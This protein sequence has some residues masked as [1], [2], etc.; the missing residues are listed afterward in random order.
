MALKRIFNRGERAVYSAIQ[1]I[2]EHHQADV[3]PKVRVADVL[4]IE[5]SGISDRHYSYALRAHFDFVVV[6]AAGIPK[7]AVEFDGSGH[8]TANDTLKNALCDKFELPLVRVTAAHLEAH[9]FEQNALQFLVYQ[10]FGVEWF[11]QNVHDPY[12]TYD[13]SFFVNAPGLTKDWP[14]WFSV[15]WRMRLARLLQQ[16]LDRVGHDMR[17]AYQLGVHSLFTIEGSWARTERLRAICGLYIGEGRALIGTAE[18]GFEFFGM[19]VRYRECFCN[20]APFV[21]GLAG[22]S[23]YENGREYLDG[24]L[25]GLYEHEKLR[26]LVNSWEEEGFKPLI[27]I[28]LPTS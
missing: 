18:L 11:L 22:S 1:A 13:P 27:R 14:F 24:G 2:A 7:L 26:G 20:L 9:N 23:M 10:A 3:F 28:N 8:D 5:N 4:P 25:S 12:E 17:S 21:L 16:E 19:E 6:D 15:R